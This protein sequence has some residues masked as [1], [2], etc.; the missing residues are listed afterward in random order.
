MMVSQV[1]NSQFVTFY[2]LTSTNIVQTS[3]NFQRKWSLFSNIGCVEIIIK[4]KYL[5]IWH[6]YKE[7]ILT[8]FEK[9]CNFLQ[10]FDTF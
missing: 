8:E 6:S 1:N 2:P 3:W 7:E 9:K 10:F 4:E 5:E